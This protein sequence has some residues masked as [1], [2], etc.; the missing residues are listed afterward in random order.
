MG[1]HGYRT[2]TDKSGDSGRELGGQGPEGTPHCHR[3]GRPTMGTLGL[4]CRGEAGQA[5]PEPH[6]QTCTPHTP[7][8]S[9]GQGSGCLGQGP[10]STLSCSHP[11]LGTGRR[12]LTV[13]AGGCQGSSRPWWGAQLRVQN[14]TPG[15]CWEGVGD[16]GAEGWPLGQVTV[17]TRKVLASRSATGVHTTWGLR[18][19]G[20]PLCG[21]LGLHGPPGLG[22]TM[23][24]VTP[25]PES[26]NPRTSG[27][28]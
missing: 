22:H 14:M 9:Q 26:R 28:S 13:G 6:R 4:L 27:M 18:A 19:P 3:P 7:H 2:V 21:G 10:A 16:R 25:W 8:R 1:S 5:G 20:A 17:A 11:D 15:C 12:M 24:W 23:G